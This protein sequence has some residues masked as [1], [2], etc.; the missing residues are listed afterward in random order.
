[1]IL[2]AIQA[3]GSSAPGRDGIPYEAYKKSVEAADIL[4]EVAG[5]TW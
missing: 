1:M 5:G 3:S 4:K 2:K